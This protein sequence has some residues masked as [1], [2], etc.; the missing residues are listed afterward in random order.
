MVLNLLRHS[1]C[2]S[3]S[4]W[5]IEEIFSNNLGCTWFHLLSLSTLESHIRYIPTLQV[6]DSG[7]CS[8]LEANFSE[9]FAYRGDLKMDEIS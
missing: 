9:L 2:V 1:I 6:L 7:E 3:S 8:G 4:L 5:G